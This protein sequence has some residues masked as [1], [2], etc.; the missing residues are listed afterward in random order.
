MRG[1]DEALAITTFYAAFGAK[2]GGLRAIEEAL[3]MRIQGMLVLWRAGLQ[4]HANGFRGPEAVCQWGPSKR[5][6]ITEFPQR[7]C[8]TAAWCQNLTMAGLLLD[9]LSFI[10]KEK[11]GMVFVGGGEAHSWTNTLHLSSFLQWM[12]S[13]IK[14]L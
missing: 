1:V 6:L 2:A 12:P 5:G 3:H 11:Y 10:P 8:Q 4:V 14:S 13:R 7:Q 9:Q